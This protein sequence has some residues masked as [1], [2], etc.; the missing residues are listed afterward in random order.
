MSIPLDQAK[1]GQCRFPVTSGD[2]AMCCG[3]PVIRARSYCCDYHHDMLFVTPTPR[4]SRSLERGVMYFVRA[5]RMD[6]GERI[7]P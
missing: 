2:V 3:A 6:I 1:R 5:E 4:Q 7:A